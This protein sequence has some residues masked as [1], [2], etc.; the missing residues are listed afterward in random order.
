MNEQIKKRSNP[1][2]NPII[3]EEETEIEV[4]Q[5]IVHQQAPIEPQYTQQPVYNEPIPQYNYQQPQPKPQKRQ[6]KPQYIQPAE[7]PKEKYTATMDV[8]LRRQIKIYCAETGKMFSEFIEEAC[9]EKL[10]RERG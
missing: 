1:F 2:D 9:R 8:T 5:P 3:V 4:Q 10:R 7:Q 6:Q